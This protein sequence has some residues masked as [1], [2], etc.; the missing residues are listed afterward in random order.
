MSSS[1]QDHRT[2]RRSSRLIAF[3]L[4]YTVVRLGIVGV[5]VWAAYVDARETRALTT[6]AEQVL[7][8]IE[9]HVT[10]ASC[11]SHVV[12]YAMDVI[13]NEAYEVHSKALVA[14]LNDAVW[15]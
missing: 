6:E 13:C 12:V 10:S 1:E 9:Y 2:L 14:A 5:M 11:F 7:H 15:Y 4:A 3:G 8:R